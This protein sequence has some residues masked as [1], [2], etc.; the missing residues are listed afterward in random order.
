MASLAAYAVGFMLLLLG[1]TGALILQFAKDDDALIAGQVFMAI[2]VC[3]ALLQAPF[4][5]IGMG[6]VER[7]RREREQRKERQ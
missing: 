1:L 2:S 6:T 5:M 3:G 7:L 4:V